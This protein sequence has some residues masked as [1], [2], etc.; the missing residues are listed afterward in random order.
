L[1]TSAS[2][3]RA[4]R[5]TS[6]RSVNSRNRQKFWRTYPMPPRSTFPFSQ[7][8]AGL[9]ALGTKLD[10]ASECEETWVE[11]HQAAIM[12]RY[13]RGQVVVVNS[14]AHPVESRKYMDVA[15]DEGFETLAVGE[16]QIR[17]PAVPI[18]QREGI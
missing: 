5:I 15:T 3:G 4:W 10:F 9:Q 11:A 2:H 17:H 12:F 7:P 18:H 13:G 1:A 14:S 6:C 16:L 8:L